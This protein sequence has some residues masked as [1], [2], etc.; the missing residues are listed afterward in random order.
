MRRFSPIIKTI[1][2][3]LVFIF[4]ANSIGYAKEPSI[5]NVSPDCGE[6][7]VEA[8]N[9]S[10]DQRIG[11]TLLE[12][13]TGS[14]CSATFTLENRTGTLLGGGYS[15]E[16]ST[17]LNNANSQFLPYGD[18]YLV[19][20]LNIEIKTTPVDINQ[21]A[22]I[23]L[24]GEV[25]L[26]SDLAV[27]FSLFLMQTALD[28]IPLPTGCVISYDQLF[29]ISLRTAPIL[30]ETT[31]LASEGDLVGSRAELSRVIV[32][33][34]EKAGD[35]A[36]DIGIGCFADFLKSI[37]GKPA[38]V[39]KIVLSYVTWVPVVIFDYFKYQGRPVSIR[40]TYTPPT[41]PTQTP[42]PTATETP[43]WPDSLIGEWRGQIS[44]PLGNNKL[45]FPTD[46]DFEDEITREGDGKLRAT[47]LI[48][49]TT[50]EQSSTKILMPDLGWLFYCFKSS[51]NNLGQESGR[52]HCFS[53]FSNDSNSIQV[54]V[55]DQNGAA[56]CR[57]LLRVGQVPF[58]NGQT[59]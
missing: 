18:P 35:Y 6:W 49:G 10:S 31:K 12:Q 15:F 1:S 7:I 46:C 44:C 21:P 48:T 8:V 28:L 56:D 42:T 14:D 37:I 41:P 59:P 43:P 50:F 57:A 16:L 55:R 3:V 47:N 29:L 58:S 11:V 27:D 22:G 40:L 23:T 20:G 45:F 17:L 4:S 25:T 9:S 19:P 26:G 30:A 13:G 52:E 33:F 54:C 51:Q 38:M 32:V 36:R 2:F 24:Q 53:P 34:N 5:P 39:A